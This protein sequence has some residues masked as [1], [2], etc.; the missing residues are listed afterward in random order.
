MKRLLL[1]LFV[2]WL[3]YFVH[4][5]APAQD[6]AFFFIYPSGANFDADGSS[7]KFTFTNKTRGCTL[8][9]AIAASGDG[10]HTGMFT[11]TVGA[12]FF[13]YCGTTPFVGD[14]IEFVGTVVKG[15]HTGKVMKWSGKIDFSPDGTSDVTVELEFEEIKPTIAVTGVTMCAGESGKTVTAAITNAPAD[16]TGYT[17]DWG[18]ANITTA[19]GSLT[20]TGA[21][22]NISTALTSS[23]TGIKASLYKD[24]TKVAES[25]AYTV[26]VN[27][28]PV[29]SV[30]P[31][32]PAV[33]S[34]EKA[35]LT[36]SGAD[37]YTWKSGS[38]TV[39]SAAT[40]NT[41]V[42]TADA[43]Y[44][45]EGTKS[46]CA[47]D[48]VTVTV[49]VNALPEMVAV[50]ADKTSVCAGEKVNLTAQAQGGSGSGYQYTWIGGPTGN[51]GTANITVA[52][53][54]NTYTAT[55]TDGNGCKSA[56]AGA[57]SVEVTGHAVTI[58]GPAD[59]TICNGEAATLV[60]VATFNPDG[61]K[62]TVS[63]AWT[64]TAG[65]IASGANDAS[66]TTRTFNEAGAAVFH[67]K[68]TDGNSCSAEKEVNVT[69]NK[70]TDPKITVTGAE[71]CQGSAGQKVKATI[72]GMGADFPSAD[73]TLDWGNPN[74]TSAGALGG[75]V[76][77]NIADNT[78]SF[79][80]TAV[81]KKGGAEVCRADYTVTVNPLPVLTSV[82]ADGGKTDVCE[83]TPVGLTATASGGTAPLTYVWG[84]G[85][86]G[87]AANASVN[88]AAGQQEYTVKIRDSKNCESKDT[89]TV[90]VTGHKVSVSLQPVPDVCKGNTANL[91]ATVTF[92][93]DVQDGASYVWTGPDI[94]TG[95]NSKNAVTAAL[96]TLGTQNYSFTA[97]DKFGCAE[98]KQLNVT[99]KDCSSPVDPEPL[100]IKT[101]SPTPTG[102]PGTPFTTGVTV[103]GGDGTYIFDWTCGDPGVTL[104]DRGGGQVEITSGTPGPKEICVTVQSGGVDPKEAC[105]DVNIAEP[106]DVFLT[107][108]VDRK[109]AYPGEFLTITITGAGADSYSF[110]LRD[111]S[112]I[113]VMTVT[114][115]M[116][117][118]TYKVYTD[119]AGIYKITDFKYT[120]DGTEHTGNIPAPVDAVFDMVPNV[121]AQA[122]HLTEISHCRGDQLLL[123]GSGDP[124]LE[125]TWDNGVRDGV[126]F[127]P[128]SSGTYTVTGTNTLTGCK[129]TN[130]VRVTVNAKPTVVAPQPQEVCAGELVTLKATGSTDATYTWNNG[131]TDGEPFRPSVTAAYEVT[132][133]NAAGCT[134]TATA[135][136][137]VNQPPHIVR[138]SKNPRNI[139]IGKDVYFA[140]T[141]EG[142]NLTYQWQKKENGAWVNLADNAAGT[143]VVL[144]TARDSL[145]LLSVPQ[146]W[147]GSEF[148]CVVSG[149]CGKDSVEFQL[150]VR[151][152]FAISAELVM[153]EGIIP[154]EVPGN[155][156]DGWYCRGQRIA[157]KAIITSEEGYEIENA[158]YKWKIDGLDIPEEHVELESD[159]AV[160]TW[161]PQFTEDDIVVEVCA[162]CDGACEEV[163]PKYIRLKAR[164]F[165]DV[166]MRIMTDKDPSHRF[167]AGDTVNFWLVTKN[168]GTKPVYTWYN[169]VFRLPEEH[170]PK[171]ELLHHGNDKIT[172]V[173]GQ[174]DT[175]VR[176]VMT[177]SQ[178]VC[179]R[180]PFIEDTVFM[181]KKDRV[182][183]SLRIVCADTL[184]CKG[185]SVYMEAVYTAA[186][187]NPAFQWQRSIGE[188]FEEWNLGDKT[189]ATVFVDEEDVWVKC[190]MTPS[191]DVCY[192]DTKP[193]VAAQ[194][195]NVL[196]NDAVVTISC[197]MEDKQAG[198][199]LVFEAEVENLLGEP[200]Y[201]W[202]ADEMKAPVSEAEYVT[203]GLKQGTVVYCMVSGDRVCQ[204]RVKSNEIVVNYGQFNRDTMLV[205]YRNESIRD[206]NM[207]K[208]E[209]DPVT[210]IFKIDEPARNG[211]G[212]ISPDGK[213]T[214]LPNA[215][216]VG[217]DVV[218][219][220]IVDR[221]SKT[222]VAE[223]YIYITVKEN[224]RFFVPNLITP[225]EDGL[226]D[227]W[228]LDFISQYPDHL[229][230]VFNRDGVLV[231]E[232]R[233]Y[234]ND[235]K[236]EGMTKGGYV[237]HIN[238]VNGIYTYIIDLGDKDKTV[239]KSWIEIRADLNRSNY[240]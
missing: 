168:A 31:A 23:L 72:T 177:P 101:P 149:D 160:L 131:V 220:V 153:Y 214:Y 121:Y 64:G 201:E 228:Q 24:G 7:V 178:E 32:T 156:I 29:I 114:K 239:L 61:E 85:P 143:P 159:T 109:C 200:R 169:D 55:V 82:V 173:M 137:T 233:N 92:V 43:T 213:F 107:M 120:K 118:D 176:V 199:E 13:N 187:E 225:N 38:A 127:E 4:G 180:D 219:Y 139:A 1:L 217:T 204:T 181:K 172:L 146:S 22:G 216:F 35:S 102:M 189:Y 158:H 129:N 203:A 59:Q 97:T 84:N 28:K 132:A 89:K 117:W 207:A 136:V 134:A 125:Y 182:T 235:W 210:L 67:L 51:A 240:R 86:A 100:V 87:T 57:K 68:V 41:A 185:D 164:E 88:V 10:L 130:T 78:A 229:I 40:Y 175:W 154:D 174:E 124:G 191:D 73:Y 126:P 211:M 20:S 77:G 108:S 62:G 166:A 103:S 39:A 215:G 119:A 152:C 186:G 81:L 133:T 190:T 49:K 26:T 209:D 202:Y 14:D 21:T 44:T 95:A 195:I 98:T 94:A 142:K 183:P 162:Y 70:C 151:E 69:V 237:G 238:L 135:T 105:F 196:R 155:L 5:Q 179:I 106:A 15:E 47:G 48:P 46:G 147:D 122:D 170:S 231:Y 226:N 16:M 218:K 230:Q 113:P 9:E 25:A 93:P 91:N 165:E 3:P 66:M 8:T 96:N 224:D 80:A 141:A 37:S 221:M 144:G 206:L 99:V 188:P 138:T 208:A 234:Q 171:N 198:D 193:M 222:Q 90:T 192:D 163:C 6:F 34:G 54:K 197:D 12:A 75:T 148:R 145:C 58:T 161:I 128:V 2:C 71:F 232:A 18:N 63:Y 19:A 227:T 27:A 11:Q 56:A 212:S 74:V 53:G 50:T 30:T 236:G 167:C 83:G 79:T 184:V 112:N 116:T 52:A 157:L 123:K 60:A 110:V 223:G 36:A 115:Q 104:V 194:R 33:C 65:D 45:V 111:K 76:D 205:I 42:L 150:G 17:I 140:L